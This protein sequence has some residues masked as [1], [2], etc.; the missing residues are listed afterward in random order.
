MKSRIPLL[1]KVLFKYKNITGENINNVLF[2]LD[3][4]IYLKY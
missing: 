2:E 4:V 3:Y 1:S